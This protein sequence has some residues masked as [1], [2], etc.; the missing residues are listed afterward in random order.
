MGMASTNAFLG[1]SILVNC[2]SLLDLLEDWEHEFY[3]LAI[4]LPKFMTGK[5]HPSLMKIISAF[6]KWGLDSEGMI[7]YLSIR[8]HIMKERNIDDWDIAACNFST[9]SG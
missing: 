5:A 2:P 1:P 7:K 3:K 6:T 4:G 8:T 9:W